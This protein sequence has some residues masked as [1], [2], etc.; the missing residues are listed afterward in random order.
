[1]VKRIESLVDEVLPGDGEADPASGPGG[2]V[3]RSGY[4]GDAA[5]GV[6]AGLTFSVNQAQ[7]PAWIGGAVTAT[8]A[9]GA[10]SFASVG[11][12]EG[13]GHVVVWTNG[14]T[15]GGSGTVIARRYDANGVAVGGEIAVG[16]VRYTGHTATV[17]LEDGGF[18]IVWQELDGLVAQRYSAAGA[19]VGDK[20]TVGPG[21]M[22]NDGPAI[23]E[24]ESG[25]FVVSYMRELGG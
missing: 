10:Q 23:T 16:S 14:F 19:A 21:G 2:I 25:G 7:P 18:M 1:M 5:A 17:G 4:G 13:G 3:R 15:S 24:V 22:V 8:A 9:G 12:L 6:S 20:V 11:A